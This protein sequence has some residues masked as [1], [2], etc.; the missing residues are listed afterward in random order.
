MAVVNFLILLL[1]T[2]LMGATLPML[3]TH[4]LKTYGSVGASTGHLY[5]VNTLGAALGCTAV[6]F[7]GFNYLTLHQV[8]MIAASLNACIAAIALIKFRKQA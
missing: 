6:G 7:A 5:H 1:P 3:V 4:F 2:C 8:I